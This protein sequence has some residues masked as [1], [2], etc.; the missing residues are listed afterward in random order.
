MGPEAAIN[1][2]FFNKIQELPEDERE[3]FIA[4][5]QT[6]F[7]EDVDLLRLASEI[8]VD[9][10]VQPSDLRRELVARLAYAA[11]KDRSFSGRRHGI[12]PV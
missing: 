2:V 6:E 11:R 7:S 1:A 8:V 10:V 3:A 12:P 5:R 9:A 4:E